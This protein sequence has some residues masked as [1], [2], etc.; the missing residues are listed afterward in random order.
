MDRGMISQI[1]PGM[2]EEIESAA[3]KGMFDLVQCS[4]GNQMTV[5]AGQP[6]YKQKDED[7]NVLSREGAKHMAKYRVR[8]N[9]CSKVFCKNCNVEPY[10]IGKTCQ[11]YEEY[12]GANKCRFCLTK[13]KKINK[14]AP[15]AFQAVCGSQTCQER[16]QE[17]C[18]K[19]LPCGHFC[20]GSRHDEI[21]M[22]CLVPECVAVSP[23]L[24][25]E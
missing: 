6:D 24:T 11:Q 19:Q 16:I 3:L 20:P 14:H 5:E 12:K 10:H 22:P 13:L 4:C 18:D 23:G 9:N 25:L 2:L 15:P 17:C 21:C 1:F 7:G 8:C